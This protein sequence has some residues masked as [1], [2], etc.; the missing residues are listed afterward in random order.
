MNPTTILAILALLVFVGLAL[1]EVFRRTGIPDVLVLLGLG[2]LAGSTGLIDVQAL[3]GIDKVFTTSALV[4]ILFEGAIQL[5]LADLRSALG[6]VLRITVLSFLVAMLVVAGV[7]IVFMGMRPLAG[8]LL[9]A[10][11]GGT[12]SA[13]VIPIVQSMKL[14]RDT[15]TALT[16]E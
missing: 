12:S 1:E 14:K 2:I 4:L 13:V 11:L 9:G 16:L 6:G 8:L 10:I 3:D 15:G 7:A 5:R